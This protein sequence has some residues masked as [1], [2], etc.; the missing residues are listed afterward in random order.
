MENSTRKGAWRVRFLFLHEKEEIWGSSV[1][2]A[3][4]GNFDKATE[5]SPRLDFQL[6]MNDQRGL[7]K[8]VYARE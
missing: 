5:C 3:Q 2:I 4:R 1:P 6:E 8:H 7:C